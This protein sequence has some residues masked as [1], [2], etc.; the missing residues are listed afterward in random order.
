MTAGYRDKARDQLPSVL[1][2]RRAF[3]S[4]RLRSARSCESILQAGKELASQ[5]TWTKRIGVWHRGCSQISACVPPP[6]SEAPQSGAPEQEN[7]PENRPQT[8]RL[9]RV[10]RNL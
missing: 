6:Q 2:I 4:W 9:N 8:N 5:P 3:A 7:V 1:D 10:R